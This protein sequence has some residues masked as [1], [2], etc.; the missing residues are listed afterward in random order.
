MH[1]WML[2]WQV[3]IF[4][5]IELKAGGKRS[6]KGSRQ[7]WCPFLGLPVTDSLPGEME[8]RLLCLLRVESFWAPGACLDSTQRH[9]VPGTAVMPQSSQ[10]CV[11][12][13]RLL[14]KSKW[15]AS[16]EISGSMHPTA[17]CMMQKPSLPWPGTNS[18]SHFQRKQSHGQHWN[19]NPGPS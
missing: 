8:P 19:V 17:S 18:S 13:I 10:A 16:R 11:L 9:C 3:K 5:E 6:W 12:V 2:C 7:P 15:D 4:S 14:D 1:S